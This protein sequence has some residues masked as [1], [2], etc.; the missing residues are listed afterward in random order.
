VSAIRETAERAVA[1]W[2][3]PL[4]AG[5]ADP[6]QG[7]LYDPA[8]RKHHEAM[9]VATS[10]YLQLPQAGAGDD[11]LHLLS[12]VAC[13]SDDALDKREVSSGLPEQ[14]LCTIPVLNAGRVNADGQQQA[15]RI[16]QDVT[17]AANHL[18][19]CV[20]PGR[21]ERSPPLSEPLAVWLSIIAV[22][23]LASRPALSRTST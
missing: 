19:A 22:V 8:L 17:L 16:G 5:L 10:D 9:T 13:I 18:L 2:Q 20:V 7:S 15:E 12:L 6:C 21:V 23:G 1:P 4:L 3:M 11:G 14:R